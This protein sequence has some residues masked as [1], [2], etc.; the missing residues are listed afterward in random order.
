[1][2]GQVVLLVVDTMVLAM[3]MLEIH[4]VRQVILVAH[5]EIILPVVVVVVH[6]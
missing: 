6:V 5:K 2:V 4:P 3:V 1:M